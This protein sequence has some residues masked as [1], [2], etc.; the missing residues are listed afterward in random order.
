MKGRSILGDFRDFQGNVTYCVTGLT[1]IRQ[2]SDV[3]PAPH[4]KVK[5]CIAISPAKIFHIT[6]GLYSVRLSIFQCGN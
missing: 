1:H 4:A 2:P 6:C 5:R 3:L